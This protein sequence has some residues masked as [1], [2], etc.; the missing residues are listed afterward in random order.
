MPEK[1]IRSFTSSVLMRVGSAETINNDYSQCTLSFGCPA[2][3]M[4]FAFKSK[5]HS[6]GD[7]YE[8]IFAHLRFGDPRIDNITD[9]K[10]RPMRN[11]LLIHENQADKTCL[12]RLIPT[13]LTPVLCFYSFNV[14]KI[15]AKLNGGYAA[16]GFAFD[17]DKYKDAI[18]GSSEDASFL[19]IKNPSQFIEELKTQVPIAVEENIDNLNP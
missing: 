5:N 11:H 7:I 16:G 12:L 3:W 18:I 6:I 10:G 15:M 13:I 14:D 4:D 17:L 9:I 8:C 2:N 1:I 19:F